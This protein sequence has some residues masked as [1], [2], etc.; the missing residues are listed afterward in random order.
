[1]FAG[2][3]EGAIGIMH[4]TDLGDFSFKSLLKTAAEAAGQDFVDDYQLMTL[5]DSV[6]E[7]NF[8]SSSELL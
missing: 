1:M 4:F 6:A 5:V 7:L 2:E 3:G 8:P